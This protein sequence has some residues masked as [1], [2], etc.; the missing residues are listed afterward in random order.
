LRDG[1]SEL[2]SF[3][4]LLKETL[5]SYLVITGLFI[6][7]AKD[8]D[9]C[10]TGCLQDKLKSCRRILM[11]FLGDC[12]DPDHDADMT[13]LNCGELCGLGGCLLFLP[14]WFDDYDDDDDDMSFCMLSLFIVQLRP[15]PG[16]P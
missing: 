9:F 6:T 14:A 11:K 4:G 13:M 1:V 2:Y 10:P 16:V 3:S 15:G 7:S 5:T 8:V 12:G